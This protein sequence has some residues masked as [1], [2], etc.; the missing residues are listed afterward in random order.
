MGS[1]AGDISD[2]LP[3]KT[4]EDAKLFSK[5]TELSNVDLEN[6]CKK[7]NLPYNFIELKD[8]DK[9][10]KRYSFV[11][12][13][14]KKN[15]FNN[16]NNKHWLLVDGNLIFDS[17]GLKSAYKFPSGF[18]IIKN[19]PKQLQEYNSTICGEYCLAFLNFL[20]Q[21]PNIKNKDLG[22]EF[23]DEYGFTE[24]RR[25]NDRTISKWYQES[26]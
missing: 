18:E 8:L 9:L 11:F 7:H 17:Y 4:K 5:K 3:I 21:N 10:N 16:G 22:V 15:E 14:D 19:H 24:N 6:F 25:D 20:I 12:T 23:S 26:M 1:I 13:G 2:N